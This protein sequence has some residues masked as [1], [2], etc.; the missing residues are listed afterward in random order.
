MI[1]SGSSR[2]RHWQGAPDNMLHCEILTIFPA[3][4]EAYVGES[5]LARAAAKGLFSATV[6]NIRDFAPGKHRST[7]DSPYGGGAGMVMKPEPVFNAIDYLKTD[8]AAR[9]VILPSP[10]G[11]R[12]DQRMAEELAAETRTLTFICGRYEGIDERVRMALVDDEVSLG[13]FVITGGE[14]ATLAIIDASVRLMPGVL[15]DD[16]SSE[17][18]S[19]SW[20]LLDYPHYTR[21]PVYRG[22]AVPDVLLSGD[23][24]KIEIWRRGE[25]LR[26]TLL[27]RPDLLDKTVLTD[28]DARLLKRLKEE[29]AQ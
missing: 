23:H 11:R 17:V 16:R 14:L 27:K 29:E 10:Q 15:G 24:R 9:R 18:D 1:S 2:R 28:E 4:I 5:I 12:F 21:P 3:M 7:D 25:A 22:M 6:V 13:D 19:F 20:G 8:G 26:N